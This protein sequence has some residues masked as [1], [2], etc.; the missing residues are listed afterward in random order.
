MEVLH[1]EYRYSVTIYSE[2][3][4]VVNCLRAPS[5]YS[6]RTGNNRIPWGGTKDGDWKRDG[7]CVTFRF[8]SADYRVGFLSE[9]KRLLPHNLWSVARQNDNDPA[10]PQPK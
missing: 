3:K 10:S 1:Y 7:A 4:A 6:Q 8:S 5:Q 9:V 2:D